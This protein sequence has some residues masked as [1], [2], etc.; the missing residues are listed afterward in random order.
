MPNIKSAVKRVKTNDK[1]RLLNASQKSALRT[2]VKAAD[3]ALANNE[4]DNAKGAV[5]LAS[6]KLDKA[7][8]KGLIHKNAA[9][10]KKSRLA[11]KLNALLAQ[12]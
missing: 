11:Q 7:V 3:A 6:K 8:T 2:A 5:A 10:R 4:V 12:A 9:A 1:R